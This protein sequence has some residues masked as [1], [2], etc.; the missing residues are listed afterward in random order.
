MKVVDNFLPK[1]DFKFIKNLLSS[2]NFPWFYG[3]GISLK[4]PRK[5]EFQFVHTFYD[6]HKNNS[7]LFFKFLDPILAKINPRLLIKAKAN[8]LTR[9]EKVINHQFHY[10]F[11]DMVTSILYF[12]TTNGPTLFKNNIKVDCIENRLVTFDSNLKHASSSC[13]DKNIRIVLNLNYYE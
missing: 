13:S 4:T 10:D 11:K 1:K 9:T 12:S 3:D 7:P 8:L 5:N 6:E 2:L